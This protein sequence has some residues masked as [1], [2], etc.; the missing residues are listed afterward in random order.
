MLS[1]ICTR[2]G[3]RRSLSSVGISCSSRR[4][5]GGLVEEESP[6]DGAFRKGREEFLTG[7]WVDGL[8]LRS[9][10]ARCAG[11][12][13]HSL[14]TSLNRFAPVHKN[15][16]PVNRQILRNTQNIHWKTWVQVQT[17]KTA[18]K[19]ALPLFLIPEN[20]DFWIYEICTNNFWTRVF[21]KIR[22]FNNNFIKIIKIWSWQ[23]NNILINR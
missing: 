1:A 12:F 3:A 11:K 7:R 14:K 6:E 23:L 8:R 17:F 20:R 13:P 4:G 2:L 9:A 22:F 15:Q 19:V 16:P 5:K 10:L 21:M 18:F